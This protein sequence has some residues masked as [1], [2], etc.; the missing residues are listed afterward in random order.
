MRRL[1][2]AV[3]V[4]GLATSDWRPTIFKEFVDQSSPSPRLFCASLVVSR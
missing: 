1:K 4:F 3:D 2:R